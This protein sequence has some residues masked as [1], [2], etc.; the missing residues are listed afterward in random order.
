[1]EKSSIALLLTKVA[2]M[3]KVRTRY[4]L[5]NRPKKLKKLTGITK[6]SNQLFKAD[7]APKMSPLDSQKLAINAAKMSKGKSSGVVNRNKLTSQK[8]G[9]VQR[10]VNT[11]K[12]G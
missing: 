5:K 9:I 8:S 3:P 11:P 4:L 6:M 7:A 12:A 1:M 10:N 2:T